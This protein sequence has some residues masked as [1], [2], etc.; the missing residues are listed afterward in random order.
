MTVVL[1]MQT[2]QM[3]QPCGYNS[4]NAGSISVVSI[5]AGLVGA[6]LMGP[7][8]KRTKAYVPLMRVS[9]IASFGGVVLFFSMLHEHNLTVCPPEVPSPPPPSV[10]PLLAPQGLLAASG[11]LGFCIVPITPLILESVAEY[12]FSQ[13]SLCRVSY[14]CLRAKAGLPRLGLH[15]QQGS[16][17]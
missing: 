7:V 9:A 13:S 15:Q 3:I 2:G 12:V 17:C 8:M 16:T 6:S 14:S 10:I 5:A 4:K 11:V 1:L